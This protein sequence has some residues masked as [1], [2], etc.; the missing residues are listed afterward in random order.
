[1]EKIETITQRNT[2]E[3]LVRASEILDSAFNTN[4]LF[5]D[6]LLGWINGN[7]RWEIIRSYYS[8]FVRFAESIGGLKLWKNPEW[9]V[10]SVGTFIPHNIDSSTLQ[11]ALKISKLNFSG[12]CRLIMNASIR[13]P[14]QKILALKKFWELDSF[15]EQM[16]KEDMGDEPHIYAQYLWADWKN[17]SGIRLLLRWVKELKQAGIPIYFWTVNPDN[18]AMYKQLGFTD[19]WDKKDIKSW[20]AF[21]RFR[22]TPGQIDRLQWNVKTTISKIW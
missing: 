5:T 12:V 14:V 3:D 19:L 10:V 16:R 11:N 21:Y 2:S 13:N 20:L 9:K 22:Y 17:W 6:Y 1:M 4:D 7:E 15:T 18:H 8:R